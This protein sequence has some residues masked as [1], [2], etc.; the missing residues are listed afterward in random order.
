MDYNY[1]AKIRAQVNL[2]IPL[3]IPGQKPGVR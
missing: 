2:Y 1:L 3:G